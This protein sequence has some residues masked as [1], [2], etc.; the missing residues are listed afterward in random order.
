MVAH[1]E[2]RFHPLGMA[3]F[4][5]QLG[6]GCILLLTTL[7]SDVANAQSSSSHTDTENLESIVVASFEA[8]AD[9]WSV[10]EVMLHDKRRARFLES[11]HQKVSTVSEKELFETLLRVRKGG[12]LKVRATQNARSSLEDY[13]IAA[14]IAARRIADEKKAHFD[15]VLCDPDLL[16]LF[17]QIAAEL[18]PNTDPY[19]LRKAALRLRK[20]RQLQPELVVQSNN[21]NVKLQEYTL[22]ELTTQLPELTTRPGIYIFRDATGYLYIGQSNNLRERLTHHLKESDRDQLRN[23]LLGKAGPELKIELHEFLEGSPGE[24]LTARR[25]YESELIRSREPRLNLAP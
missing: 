2:T 18:S 23:Y 5:F 9:G 6:L 10:D 8:S 24:K 12:R 25:A 22:T 13:T 11:C 21:W 14:E 15:Q 19:L 20:S 1:A 16:Q 3:S 17:D 4:S 7:H